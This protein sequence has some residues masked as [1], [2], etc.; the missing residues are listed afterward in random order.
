FDAEFRCRCVHP[1]LLSFSG[2]PILSDAEHRKQDCAQRCVQLESTST[3]SSRRSNDLSAKV[4]TVVQVTRSSSV[5]C[6]CCAGYSIQA[7]ENASTIEYHQRKLVLDVIL[8]TNN[9]RIA[10]SA[11]QK[12]SSNGG[13]FH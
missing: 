7:G 1:A 6:S 10:A 13:S 11:S 12:P 3:P 2:G 5:T 9:S 4:Q 8:A